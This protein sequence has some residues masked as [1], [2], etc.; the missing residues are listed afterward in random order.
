MVQPTQPADTTTRNYG[1]YY[2]F[3]SPGCI[4]K[5]REEIRDLGFQ[6]NATFLIENLYDRALAIHRGCGTA[7]EWVRTLVITSCAGNSLLALASYP[8]RDRRE[9]QHRCRQVIQVEIEGLITEEGRTSR[10]ALPSGFHHGDTRVYAAQITRLFAEG[11]C[12]CGGV[13]RNGTFDEASLSR[14]ARNCLYGHALDEFSGGLPTWKAFLCAAVLGDTGM[15][16]T[17]IK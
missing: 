15:I 16:H 10:R 7:P 12:L 9:L 13:D 4:A 17:V 5:A 14:N 1:S 8:L 2:Q 11:A 3:V 6:P